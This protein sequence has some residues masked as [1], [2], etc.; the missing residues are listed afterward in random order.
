MQDARSEIE[1]KEWEDPPKPWEHIDIDAPQC[2]ADRA[3]W[4]IIDLRD[5]GG[6]RASRCTYLDGQSHTES[7]VAVKGHSYR[8]DAIGALVD[9]LNG[10]Q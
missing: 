5:E 9:K 10:G 8:D 3:R 7:T 2:G 4:Y 1:G 6:Y